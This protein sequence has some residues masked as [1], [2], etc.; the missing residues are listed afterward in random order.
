[1]FDA[2]ITRRSHW[3]EN[4]AELMDKPADKIKVLRDASSPEGV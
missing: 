3:R 4:L 2:Y 1:M